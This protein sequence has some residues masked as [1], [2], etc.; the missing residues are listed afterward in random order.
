MLGYHQIKVASPYPIQHLSDLSIDWKPG[1]HGR[2]IIKGTS[3][4]AHQ[5]NAALQASSDDH[6]HVYAQDGERKVTLF[7][8]IVNKVEVTHSQGV[9]TVG[10]EG[11][12]GSFQL[13]VQKRKRSFPEEKQTYSQLIGK[14]IQ[15]Y[16]QND[17]LYHT[18]GKAV[19]GEAILQYE[20]TDW[21]LVKRLA[22]RL[23]TI[24]VCD[25]LESA[26]AK[27][28]F[29]LPTGVMRSVDERTP[30]QASKDLW[31]YQQAGGS[32]AGLHD[33]DFFTYEIETGEL[34]ELGDSVR[35][36]NKEMIVSEMS[37]R[38]NKGQLVFRYK[39]SRPDGIR[40]E[41]IPNP[42]TIGISLE[43]DVLDVRGEEVKLRL[44]IDKDDGVS[45][46]HWYPFAPPTG[47]AMYCMPQV[48]TKASLYVPDA[49]GSRAMILGS[50]RT[51][52][53]SSEKTGDA[54]NRYFGTEHGS[55]LKLGPDVVH[56]MGDPGGALQL[57]L[58]DASGIEIK[59]PKKLTIQADLELSLYTPKQIVF[60]CNSQLM[61]YQTGGSTGISVESEY[62][63]LGE[64]V[65][66]EGSDR[67]AYPPFDDEPKE[68]KPPE[69]P[70]P[71]EPDPFDWG[72]LLTNV[73]I[74][75]AVV[76]A[77]A[78]VAVLTVAT[79]GT[80][81]MVAV[82]VGAVMLG[83]AGVVGQAVSD[84]R[85]G[86]V[87][88]VMDY[89]TTAVRESAIGA[90]SGALFGP[91]GVSGTLLGRM[92]VGGGIGIFE[93]SASQLLQGKEFSWKEVAIAGAVGFVS[94][95]IFDPKVLGAVGGALKTGAK[96]GA[97]LLNAGAKKGSEW[98]TAGLK[99]VQNGYSRTVSKLKSAGSEIA[100]AISQA[101]SHVNPKNYGVLDTGMGA[102]VIGKVGDEPL[103]SL[104]GNGGGRRVEE[105]VDTTPPNSNKPKENPPEG[106]GNVNLT[107]PS[108][109][110]GGKPKGN[111]TKGDSHGIKKE[112]E[113]ADLMAD[114]GYDIE[115]LDEVNGGNGY[116]IK[117]SSNPDFLIEGK[118]FDCY[119]PTIETN[120]DNILRNTTKK[121]KTQAERIVLNLDQFP[122]EKVAE[123]IQGILRKANPNGDL[124]NLKELFIVKDGEITRVFGG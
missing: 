2:V 23:H 19:V 74:G 13:D 12:S 59:S 42:Q 91:L 7:K 83:T 25:I 117:E 61:A 115:M 26:K 111:Y 11:I 71:P 72:K 43:G 54:N 78:A 37:A 88:D 20:E 75:I 51:N 118:V 92:G 5:I 24:V 95:G 84:Y 9:H 89:A 123:I 47:S 8:G 45:D 58:N 100:G 73:A 120:V 40:S 62:H 81:T 52:G 79:L 16:E 49:S 85:S 57:S 116:G 32:S 21:E 107:E 63:L 97:E 77:V 110:K 36:R 86:E 109:P 69:P 99:G 41:P 102:K 22:S 15:G 82:G 29:G 98:L 90:V 10:I 33:T 67:T 30:Y 14:L 94:A 1:E 105:T 122:S 76:V 4:E 101:S 80:A 17:V 28:H 31:A 18:G 121:T 38:M 112:S 87:S 93:N 39:L 46:P 114:Q 65:K 64:N 53:G 106:T 56:I 48:G 60:Q 6:I 55:E 124:K 119:A 113:T 66:A 104:G 50:V 3:E 44:A 34:F 103:F 70:A 68:G 27:L 96:K 108:L 35:F